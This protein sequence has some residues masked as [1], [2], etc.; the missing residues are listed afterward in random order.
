MKLTTVWGIFPVVITY[1]KIDSTADGTAYGPFIKL[2]DD[3]VDDQ[4]VTLAH[5]LVHAKQFYSLLLYIIVVASLATVFN[6]FILSLLVP[7]IL[8]RMSKHATLVLESAAYGESARQF[9]AR[10]Q[11]ENKVISR[12]ATIL[13]QSELYKVNKSYDTIKKRIFARYKDKRI[14]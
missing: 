11:E 13:D 1:A 7:L 2:A 6:L 5:E 4:K 10:G 8:W 14:F 12:L 9:V 3:T